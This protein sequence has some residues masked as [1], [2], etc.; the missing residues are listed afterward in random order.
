MISYEVRIDV[1]D[2]QRTRYEVFMRDR[3]IPDVLATGLVLGAHFERAE[4]EG[5]YR[6]RFEFEDQASLDRYLSVHAPRL[7]ADFLTHFPEGATTSREVWSTLRR[8]PH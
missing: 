7:R 6:V 8:W 3:H 2:A 5:R 1:S 4:D